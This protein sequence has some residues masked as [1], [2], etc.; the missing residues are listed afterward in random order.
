METRTLEQ[1]PVV[2]SSRAGRRSTEAVPVWLCRTIPRLPPGHFL[3]RRHEESQHGEA[4]SSA[5]AEMETRA[6]A[7]RPVVRTSRTGRR[8]TA[9]VPVWLCRE[10]SEL[11]ETDRRVQKL[12]N[13]PRQPLH[14]ETLSAWLHRTAAKL[15]EADRRVQELSTTPRQP[16]HLETLPAWLRRPATELQKGPRP[17]QSEVLPEGTISDKRPL[18]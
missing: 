9:E 7:Q 15:Q 17:R 1:R 12:S 13:T 2:R 8:P 6:L 14:L 5:P 11:Q 10:V 3:P 4:W 16:L 18:H